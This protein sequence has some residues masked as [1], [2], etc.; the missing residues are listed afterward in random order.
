MSSRRASLKA[1]EE[2]LLECQS[3]DGVFKYCARAW[4]ELSLTSEKLDTGVLSFHDNFT[5]RGKHTQGREVRKPQDNTKLCR[6]LNLSHE[7]LALSITH[8][9][10]VRP[11]GQGWD[12]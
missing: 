1:F 11:V 9:D 10:S 4:S 3:R 2:E 7:G 5:M 6:L 12:S 8:P